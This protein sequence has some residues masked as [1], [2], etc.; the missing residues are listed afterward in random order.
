MRTKL[1]KD[2]EVVL[3]VRQHW[4]VLLKPILVFALIVIMYPKLVRTDPLGMGAFLDSLTIFFE[5]ASIF[6]LLYMVWDRRINI[7]AVTNV[8]LIDEWGVITHHAKESLLEKINN[9]DI[10][11]PLMGQVLNYGSVSIQ[12]AATSGETWIRYVA[13]PL[14][15]QDTIMRMVRA[16]KEKDTQK[17]IPDVEGSVMDPRILGKEAKIYKCPGCGL[18]F[19]ESALESMKE[20][21]AEK[22][23]SA[24]R[25]AE[26][27]G[28][29]DDQAQAK[30]IDNGATSADRIDPN[31]WK[32]TGKNM[33]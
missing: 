25:A 14:I 23:E 29:G 10:R 5:S 13:K 15:L 20:R 19:H 7:W 3:I 26:C 21:E 1:Q 22:K 18:I 6:Y 2:E 32:R 16:Y 9:V 12:T 27:E 4:V 24:D 11:Q 17:R 30:N 31:E 28:L 8:R 33:A